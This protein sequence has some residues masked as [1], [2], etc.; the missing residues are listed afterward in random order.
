MELMGYEEGARRT[1]RCKD[2]GYFSGIEASF[3][4][5]NGFTE[6]VAIGLRLRCST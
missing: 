2:G 1:V 4:T 6:R 5:V 3:A